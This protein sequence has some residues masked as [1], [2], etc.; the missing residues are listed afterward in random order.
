A[1]EQLTTCAG[2]AVLFHTA[3]CVIDGGGRRHRALDTT[4]VKFRPLQRDE[5]VRYCDT[6]QPFDCAGS[7]KAEG[8]GITLFE[9]IDSHDPTAL[10]GLPLI[11]TAALLRMLGFP[12]P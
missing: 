6:E 3:L 7:F 8:L 5:I 11:R 2:A 9:R 1:I 12:L 4:T 10:I